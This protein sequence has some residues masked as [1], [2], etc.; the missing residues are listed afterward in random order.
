MKMQTFVVF[1]KNNLKINVWK[2]KNIAKYR[3]NRIQGNIE[4]LRIVHAI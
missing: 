4:V 2:I 3:E 1:V